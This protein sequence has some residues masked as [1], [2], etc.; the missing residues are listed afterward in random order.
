MNVS[1]GWTIFAEIF[2]WIG[3]SHM[4]TLSGISCLNNWKTSVNLLAPTSVRRKSFTLRLK[5]LNLWRTPAVW[6]ATLR[7]H[8]VLKYGKRLTLSHHSP[9]RYW[10]ELWADLVFLTLADMERQWFF[11]SCHGRIMIQH[12]RYRAGWRVTCVELHHERV[13]ET[14]STNMYLVLFNFF[15]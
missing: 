1:S 14:R 13:V 2:I 11:A 6:N 10:A 8:R 4:G 12:Q 3:S 7:R 9:V 5:A 15:F